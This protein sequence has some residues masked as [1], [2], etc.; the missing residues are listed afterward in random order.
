MQVFWPLI[1]KKKAL[2]WLP[3]TFQDKVRRLATER[4]HDLKWLAHCAEIPYT[5]LRR[6]LR[7]G[8]SQ[9]PPAP[10]GLLLAQVLEVSA[11][12]LFDDDLDWPPPPAW[13]KGPPFPIYPWPPEG[14]TWSDVQYAIWAFLADSYRSGVRGRSD[15]EATGLRREAPTAIV[16]A[17]GESDDAFLKRVEQLVSALQQAIAETRKSSPGLSPKVVEEIRT[18]H[19]SPSPPTEHVAS[20]QPPP[21][22]SG[23]PAKARA[24]PRRSHRDQADT[25]PSPPADPLP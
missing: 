3:M 17:P 21:S 13:A 9:R 25:T 19:R 1:P 24:A 22:S 18:A 16:P 10:Q 20:L 23:R 2:A 5:S 8:T 12:W 14:I 11:E 6:Y 15:A 7:A 4:G